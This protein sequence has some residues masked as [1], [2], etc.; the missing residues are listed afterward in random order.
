MSSKLSA[1]LLKN[2]M[3]AAKDMILY[4]IHSN[5]GSKLIPF[6][7]DISDPKNMQ[8][9]AIFNG[10]TLYRQILSPIIIVVENCFPINESNRRI[11]IYLNEC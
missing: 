4:S 5:C 8:I 9:W 11:L 2:I 1:K 3:T 7:I 10:K 6:F